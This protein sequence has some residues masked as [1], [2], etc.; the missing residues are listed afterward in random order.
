[1]RANAAILAAC[2]MA[3]VPGSAGPGGTAALATDAATPAACGIGRDTIAALAEATFPPARVSDAFLP[4]AA[5][6]GSATAPDLDAPAWLEERASE[7]AAIADAVT[8]VDAL[9]LDGD[10]ALAVWT[11]TGNAPPEDAAAGDGASDRA[12]A[13]PAPRR[14]HGIDL[15][16]LDCGGGGGGGRIAEV[17]SLVQRIE[18]PAAMPLAVP[19]VRAC[20]DPMPVRPEADAAVRTWLVD[21]WSDGDLAAVDAIIDPGVAY[22]SVPWSETTGPAGIADAIEGTQAAFPDVRSVP[23]PAVIDGAWAGARWTSTGT[24]TGGEDATGRAATWTGIDVLRLACGK[25]VEIWSV[26]DT[27]AVEAQLGT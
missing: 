13:E 23:D 19:P 16:R 17:W 21:G 27:A 14:W 6:H 9:L 24:N 7:R 2:L 1:M 22:H 15:Y 20:A 12:G 11:V 5:V 3:I 10:A 4:D 25:V 8:V 26:E 18:D